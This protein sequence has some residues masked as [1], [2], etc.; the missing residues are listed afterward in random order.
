[1]SGPGQWSIIHAATGRVTG[2]ASP[3][4]WFTSAH[5]H[6]ERLTVRA[7]LQREQLGGGAATDGRA[8]TP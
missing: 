2:A 5:E 1:M 4:A 6:G 8:A 3:A 7:V